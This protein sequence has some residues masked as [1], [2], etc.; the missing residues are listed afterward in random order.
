MIIAKQ[1]IG[2]AP[3][4]FFFPL[5]CERRGTEGED[6][7]KTNPPSPAVTCPQKTGPVIVLVK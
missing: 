7:R 5:L 1:K 6:C 4:S 2:S 3:L